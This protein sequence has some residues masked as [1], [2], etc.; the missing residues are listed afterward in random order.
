SNALPVSTRRQT[1]HPP[2][3]FTMSL[4]N[5]LKKTLLASV[6]ALG[7]VPT[8]ASAQT[9]VVRANVAFGSGGAALQINDRFEH[10]RIIEF[11][12]I[13]YLHEHARE[14]ELACVRYDHGFK[15][16]CYVE[17]ENAHRA[18]WIR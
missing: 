1:P 13:Q 10:D 2:E 7:L 12:R 16:R 6:L 3:M 15:E 5:N 14:R 11:R 17:W 9:E 18:Y 4:I 8:V